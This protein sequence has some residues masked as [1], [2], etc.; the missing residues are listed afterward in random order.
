MDVIAKKGADARRYGVA[1]FNLGGQAR[2][3][4]DGLCTADGSPFL[5][6]W[7]AETVA[8]LMRL[9]SSMPPDLLVL[10]E[11]ALGDRAPFVLEEL[12]ADSP[13]V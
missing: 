9:A 4:L 6:A 2:S 8:E 3:Q 1:A 11:A 5:F 10:D 12:H 7:A 13:R